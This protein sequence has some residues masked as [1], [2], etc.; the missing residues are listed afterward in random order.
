MKDKIERIFKIYKVSNIAHFDGEEVNEL[1]NEI[2][3]ELLTEVVNKNDLLQRVSGSYSVDFG[4]HCKAK[5]QIENGEPKVEAAMNGWGDG[6]SLSD[7]TIEK[8]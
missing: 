7:I 5:M 3:A 1:L 6:I 4:G 2:K 8:L